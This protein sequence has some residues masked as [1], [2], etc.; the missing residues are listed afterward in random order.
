MN[1]EAIIIAVI[2]ALALFYYSQTQGKSK[3]LTQG[4]QTAGETENRFT[5]ISRLKE[6]HRAEIQQL[7]KKV[8][9]LTNLK[10]LTNWSESDQETDHQE[11]INKLATENQALTNSKNILQTGLETQ[12]EKFHEL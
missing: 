3:L 2:V 12:Q 8:E 6:E 1:K 7:E 4:T 11:Q 5:I 10:E 9:E